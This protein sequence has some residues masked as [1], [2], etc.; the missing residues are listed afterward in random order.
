MIV[1]H[2]VSSV[3]GP[4]YYWFTVSLAWLTGTLE[5]NRAIVNIIS[6]TSGFPLWHSHI[7]ALEKGLLCRLLVELLSLLGVNLEELLFAQLCVCMS[8]IF[9]HIYNI[10]LRS[11][12]CFAAIFSY[13]FTFFR[14]YTFSAF[15]STAVMHNDTMVGTALTDAH[16]HT[17][18]HTWQRSTLKVWNDYEMLYQGPTDEGTIGLVISSLKWSMQLFFTCLSA[19][20]LQYVGF[21]HTVVHFIQTIWTDILS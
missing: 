7:S 14:Y 2:L 20:N 21:H 10:C 18:G 11:L 6:N 4:P 13:R 9:V 12:I 17:F 16:P 15:H 1:F 19:I 8:N 5:W 3:S